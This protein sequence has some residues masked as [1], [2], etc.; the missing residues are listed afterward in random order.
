[1]FTLAK[2]NATCAS[3]LSH[4][5]V[6][7][8][9]AVKRRFLRQACATSCVRM[10]GST[11]AK[12]HRNRI[13]SKMEQR[14]QW[15]ICSLVLRQPGNLGQYARNACHYYDCP[16]KVR[17]HTPER[18]FPQGVIAPCRFV[19]RFCWQR[20]CPQSATRSNQC[21]IRKRKERSRVVL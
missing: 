6:V 19:S 15:L 20:N 16:C 11:L 12:L 17:M 8:W 13:Y 5:E 7:S 4:L 10:P 14:R 9:H 21:C 1:M 3:I 18:W 2:A